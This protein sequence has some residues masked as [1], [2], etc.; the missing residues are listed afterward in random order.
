MRRLLLGVL[1]LAFAITTG[2]GIWQIEKW[3]NEYEEAVKFDSAFQ[4]EILE[5]YPEVTFVPHVVSSE[6]LYEEDKHIA[7]TPTLF[8]LV[9]DPELKALHDP[10]APHIDVGIDIIGR[11]NNIVRLT[12]AASMKEFRNHFVWY[13]ELHEPPG[14]KR[15]FWSVKDD[16]LSHTGAIFRYDN[17]KLAYV[18]IVVIAFW[19]SALTV[20]SLY[21]TISPRNKR[22]QPPANNSA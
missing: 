5:S 4:R 2:I 11:N 13:R 22:R 16:S 20:F 18:L 12:Y 19:G 14:G 15:E 9:M 17:S 7:S 8:M 10:G 21:T 3:H 1:T 6:D